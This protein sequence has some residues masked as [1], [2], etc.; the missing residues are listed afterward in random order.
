MLPITSYSSG[1]VSS[2]ALV[3]RYS[4]NE[5]KVETI[6]PHEYCLR[7]AYVGNELYTISSSL[8]KIFDANT[9][10]ELGQIILEK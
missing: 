7:I 5:L 8:I 10:E 3:V 6:L 1:Y 2:G 4:N 9:Y